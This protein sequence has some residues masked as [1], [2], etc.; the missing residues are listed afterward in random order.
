MKRIAAAARGAYAYVSSPSRTMSRNLEESVMSIRMRRLAAR[1]FT[2]IEVVIVLA[3]VGVLAL[4]IVP[5][6]RKYF[7]RTK[8]VEAVDNLNTIYKSSLA[9]YEAQS[10]A[11]ANKGKPQ[12]FPASTAD[13]PG[14]NTC[15]GQ[16]GDKCDPAKAAPLW[17]ASPTWS[18][19]GFKI[20]DTFYFWYRYESEGA[21]DKAT[22]KVWASA[23]LDCD[24]TY[25]TFMRGG[26]IDDSGRPTSSGE[27]YINNETE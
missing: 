15:C 9:W 12:R 26:R 19:L 21:D 23:N 14:V 3:V 16:P 11:P 10:T 8:T 7:R 1:G 18:A 24:D 4:V 2:A 20:E 5:Q 17:K 22:F 13:T 25:S 27:M 6:L